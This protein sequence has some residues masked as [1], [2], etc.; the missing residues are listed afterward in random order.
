[1]NIKKCNCFLYFHCL[2]H[3]Q[4]LVALIIFPFASRV[5]DLHPLLAPSVGA[6]A[7]VFFDFDFEVVDNGDAVG[8]KLDAA[9][10]RFIRLFRGR[11]STLAQIKLNC[12]FIN[13]TCFNK[14]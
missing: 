11:I 14:S 2:N 3:F 4:L 13:A 12:L 5:K 10:Y 6:V 1:M 7:L 9:E 8:S